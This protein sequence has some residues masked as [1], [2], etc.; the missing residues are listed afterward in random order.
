MVDFFEPYL[1]IS[2]LRRKMDEALS[3]VSA[4]FADAFVPR[5]EAAMMRLMRAAKYVEGVMDDIRGTVMHML[6]RMREVLRD[7][8]VHFLD[9]LVDFV[10]KQIAA[11]GMDFVLH[12]L[13]R[14]LTR[15]IG[16]VVRGGGAIARAV[17][18][19][20]VSYAQDMY[21]AHM[22]VSFVGATKL[23]IEAVAVNAKGLAPRVIKVCRVVLLSWWWS[24]GGG[25]REINASECVPNS[26]VLV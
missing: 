4:F 17:L 24:R 11:A 8:P 14:G 10:E 23:V 25:F 12:D 9:F 5:L 2:E 21:K 13:V 15:E 19:E 22:P 3:L 20:F 26:R 18:F 16:E 7:T 1:P 6:G